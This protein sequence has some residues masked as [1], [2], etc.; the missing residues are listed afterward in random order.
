MGF[1]EGV[2]EG[3][4]KTL[5]K[6]LRCILFLAILV[7]LA[8]SPA[9]ADPIP[10]PGGRPNWLVY[11]VEALVAETIAW[12]VGSELLWRLMKKTMARG[13]ERVSRSNAYRIML[14]SM[15][16]SFFVGLLVAN[17]LGLF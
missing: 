5:D 4:V 9:L 3:K 11:G 16:L 6:K 2:S 15:L 1:R 7:S 8:V 13:A 17:M 12:I 14:A 10:G